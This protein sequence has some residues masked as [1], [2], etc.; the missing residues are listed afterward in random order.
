[1]SRLG[2]EPLFQAVILFSYIYC[3]PSTNTGY[4]KMMTRDMGK[5]RKGFLRRKDKGR[6]QSVSLKNTKKG[7][8]AGAIRPPPCIHPIATET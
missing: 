7:R 2:R 5:R 3:N 8:E 6:G 4:I 1:M